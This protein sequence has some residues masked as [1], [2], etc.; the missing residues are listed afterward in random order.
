MTSLSRGSLAIQKF[1]TFAQRQPGARSCTQ[2]RAHWVQGAG[3]FFVLLTLMPA[4]AGLGD[5]ERTI[6]EEK[7]KMHARHSVSVKPQYSV[8]DLQNSDGANIRQ[9]V[10]RDGRVF[11][12][13]WHT[14]YKPD[15]S[16]ILGSSYL[17]YAQSTRASAQRFGIQ[18]RF[19]HESLEVVVQATAHL[20]VFSGYAFR[21]SML[22][23]GF[24]PSILGLE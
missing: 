2:G 14:L 21:Q 7:V 13:V 15:L 9:Y 22:P 3:A 8:H 4:W 18:R 23:P 17:T 10:G 12:V 19:R 6:Q 1:Q 16:S 20:N 11:A 24:S 5:F